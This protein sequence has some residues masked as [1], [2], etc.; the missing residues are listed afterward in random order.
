MLADGVESTVV[1]EIERVMGK[2]LFLGGY[3]NKKT[4]A[5]YHHAAVQTNPKPRPPSMI[6]KNCRDTQT[7]EARH[8]Q[9]QTKND[10]STQMTGIGV[11]IANESDKLLKPGRYQTADDY[12]KN[13]F[14]QV[15]L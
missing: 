12:R 6:E 7:V 15:I 10:T 3:R 5:E 1:V 8:L 14:K 2:K 4:G 9:Q 13:I 11:Y